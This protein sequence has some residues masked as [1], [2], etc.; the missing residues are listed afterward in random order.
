VNRSN[1][2]LVLEPI[3]RTDPRILKDMAQHYSQ[4]KGFVGRN[5]CYAVV[6]DGECYGSIA[7]GSAT[8][9]LA[10]RDAFFGLTDREVKLIL[11][12]NIVNNTFYHVERRK[13]KYP[14]RNFVPRVLRE[15]RRVAQSAWEAKYG[16]PVI[17]FETLIELPRTGEA[18]AR[19][20]WTE[21]GVTKGFTC[22]RSG[23][24]GTDSWSGKRVWDTKNLRPKRV[25]V[26]SIAENN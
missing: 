17:G 3:K 16:D 26:R 24:K 23:G 14:A 5:I 6:F 10:G 25:F 19:D 11:L 2:G 20:G 22:K 7:G 21:V 4:P 1:A 8:M 15:F 13:G 12:N 9:H 18:Y